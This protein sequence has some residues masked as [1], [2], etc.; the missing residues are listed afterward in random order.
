MIRGLVLGLVDNAVRSLA[1]L[2]QL[3]IIVG[4]YLN[5]FIGTVEVELG[6][7]RQLFETAKFPPPRVQE[8]EKLSVTLYLHNIVNGESTVD[9]SAKTRNHCSSTRSTKEAQTVLC[10]SGNEEGPR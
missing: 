3:Q 10:M 2:F 4:H 5:Y 1:N 9:F 7:S 8:K 6:N